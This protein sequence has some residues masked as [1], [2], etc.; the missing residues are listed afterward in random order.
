MFRGHHRKVRILLSLADIL[1]VFL[2]FEFAYALRARM[3]ELEH[4]F[5]LSPQVKILLM[6]WSML[7]WVGLGY[8]WEIYD[9]V[10]VAEI[11]GHPSGRVPAVPGGRGFGHPF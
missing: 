5:F 6:G 7:V 10:D 9:R 2:A 1:L 11:A 4:R 3:P 8:W